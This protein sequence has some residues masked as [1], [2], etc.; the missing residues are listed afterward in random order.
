[1]LIYELTGPGYVYT[2][3]ATP[4]QRQRVVHACPAIAFTIGKPL[5]KLLKIFDDGR[6]KLIEV[7]EQ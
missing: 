4:G 7:R 2:V 3:C 5:E 1:M 6:L